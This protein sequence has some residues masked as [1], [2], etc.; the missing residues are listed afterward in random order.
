MESAC[1]RHS[2]GLGSLY[3]ERRFLK[4]NTGLFYSWKCLENIK[5]WQFCLKS[6]AEQK[7]KSKWRVLRLSE[8]CCLLFVWDNYSKL[9]PE[10]Q[11]QSTIEP[12]GLRRANLQR[13]RRAFGKLHFDNTCRRRKP[14][15]I[16]RTFPDIRYQLF[17]MVPV[18]LTDPFVGIF[19]LNNSFH[20]RKLP[21]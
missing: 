19:R 8:H 11:N 16:G 2:I 20:T 15:K 17:H 21:K 3:V 10:F 1:T 12:N 13:L 7:G 18:N 14:A 5:K 4:D 9:D 6:C